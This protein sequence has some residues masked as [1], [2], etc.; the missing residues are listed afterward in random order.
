MAE[1]LTPVGEALAS[2]RINLEE[3]RWDQSSYG[4]RAK[5][6]FTTTNP[7]NVFASSAD[8]DWAKDVVTKYRKVSFTSFES[9]Q[10]LLPELSWRVVLT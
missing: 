1:S 10:S 7:L 4:G 8:L 5:H 2:G 9:W 3:P 6:F